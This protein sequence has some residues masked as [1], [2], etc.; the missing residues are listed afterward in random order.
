MLTRNQIQKAQ[1]YWKGNPQLIGFPDAEKD[2]RAWPSWESSIFLNFPRFQS[3]SHGIANLVIGRKGSGKTAALTAAQKISASASSNSAKDR[4]VIS[5]DA[6]RLVDAAINEF[7]LRNQV[8]SGAVAVWHKAFAT[9]ILKAFAGE[10]SGHALVEDAEVKVR[11]WALSQ[12]FAAEDF[13]ERLISGAKT[14]FPQIRSRTRD[15]SKPATLADDH[16][17]TVLRRSNYTLFVD[18]FDNP[19]SAGRLNSRIGTEL[20]QSAIEAADI[21]SAVYESPNVSLLIREDLW[22][23]CRIDWHY[24]DKVSMPQWLLWKPDQLKDFIKR[25]LA[26]AVSIALDEPLDSR[27]KEPFDIL[28]E[29][30]FPASVR[31]KTDAVSQGFTYVLR[32]TMYTPRDLQTFLQLAIH[33]TENLPLSEENILNA[34]E[35]FSRERLQYLI[36]EFGDICEGLAQCLH[37][38][39]GHSLDWKTTELR[40]HLKGLMGQGSV[41]PSKAACADTRSVLDLM[42]FLFRIGFLEVRLQDR[43]G[44]NDGRWEVRDGLR[45]PDHWSGARMDD[46]VH[47]AV[48]STFYSA[49]RSYRPEFGSGWRR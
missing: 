12:G 28:W 22:L 3:V 15:Q 27:V 19:G 45:H 49:L 7:H 20:A 37:S 16:I 13:G 25:R 5:A 40:S 14:L 34:E 36:N 11:Q 32:R 6:Q 18:N 35:H 42:R 30:F 10:L 43:D 26:V 41:R 8:G 39:A 2:C 17:E 44:A 23:R 4:T 33:G 47:W 21:L 46:S 24:L 29:T 9:E 31:L 38:F 1:S 48:R